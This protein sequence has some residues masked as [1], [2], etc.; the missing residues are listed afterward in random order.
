[1]IPASRTL[2]YFSPYCLWSLRILNDVSVTISCNLTCGVLFFLFRWQMVI[3]LPLWYFPLGCSRWGWDLVEGRQW[4]VLPFRN[5]E[6]TW[7]ILVCHNAI[8]SRSLELE[9]SEDQTENPFAAAQPVPAGSGTLKTKAVLSS[10]AG[11]HYVC[12]PPNHLLLLILHFLQVLMFFK[13]LLL[14]FVCWLLRGQ[15]LPCPS[16]AIWQFC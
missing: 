11:T 8:A 1:M 15:S 2:A 12:C 6:P 4:N 16:F 5:R 7:V 9:C 13:R 3:Y 10:S 14:C